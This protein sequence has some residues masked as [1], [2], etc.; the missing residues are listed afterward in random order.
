MFFEG[1]NWC[2]LE[3]IKL[4]ISLDGYVYL[5]FSVYFLVLYFLCLYKSF[6]VKFDR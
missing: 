6:E 1:V 3:L 4:L 5:F 2:I